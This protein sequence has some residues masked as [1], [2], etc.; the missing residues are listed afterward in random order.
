MYSLIF[1]QIHLAPPFRL[2]IKIE[3]SLKELKTNITLR[4]FFILILI[5]YSFIVYRK[6]CPSIIVFFF[7]YLFL[8][9]DAFLY[10]IIV[11]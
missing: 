6:I 8:T 3:K 2:L 9:K 7:S 4:F 11:S 5:H 10:I 1:K